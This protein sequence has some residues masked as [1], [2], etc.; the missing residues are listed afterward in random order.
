[1]L[2][3]V[4]SAEERG[5]LYPF[6]GMVQVESVGYR[7]VDFAPA[8]LKSRALNLLHAAAAA[9][10]QPESMAGMYAYDNNWC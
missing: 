7:L 9:S 10:W 6:S 3:W 2:D 5:T 8:G 4:V 1:M